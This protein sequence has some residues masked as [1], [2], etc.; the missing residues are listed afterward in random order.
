[1]G[2]IKGNLRSKKGYAQMKEC[3]KCKKRA[4]TDFNAPNGSR[5][6]PFQSQQ[7]RQDG[8]SPFC[9]FSASFLIKYDVTDAILQDKKKK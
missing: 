4:I 6:I 9:R 1:M 7:F 5:Y 3:E 8:T 2:Q